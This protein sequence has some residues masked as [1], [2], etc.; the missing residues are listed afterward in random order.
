MYEGRRQGGFTFCK[1]HQEIA[2][3]I[4]SAEAKRKLGIGEYQQEM[5]AAEKARAVAMQGGLAQAKRATNR[6]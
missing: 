1:D 5:F 3:H 2:E 4:I 6:I